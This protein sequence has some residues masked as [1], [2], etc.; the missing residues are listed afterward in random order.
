MSHYVVIVKI[1]RKGCAVWGVVSACT[2]PQCACAHFVGGRA[3]VHLPVR[4]RRAA[5]KSGKRLL[6]RSSP[7][8]DAP[9]IRRY[10]PRTAL[11]SFIKYTN[12]R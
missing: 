7:R 9:A 11:G 6:T 3:N 4:A 12:R 10:A 2:R 5:G 8:S 1:E